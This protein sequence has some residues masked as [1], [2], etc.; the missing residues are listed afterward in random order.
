MISSRETTRESSG[1]ESA[2][3]ATNAFDRLVAMYAENNGYAPALADSLL[4]K[5]AEEGGLSPEDFARKVFVECGFNPDGTE[6]PVEA[7]IAESAPATNPPV[8]AG[9]RTR[10]VSVRGPDGK[11]IRKRVRIPEEQAVPAVDAP[12]AGGEAAIAESA[13]AAKPPVVDSIQ[14][15]ADSYP[16]LP[17]AAGA[18]VINILAAPNGLTWQGLEVEEEDLFERIGIF[19]QSEPSAFLRIQAFPDTPAAIVRRIVDA[20]RKAGFS[21]VSVLLPAPLRPVP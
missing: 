13:P 6:K 17:V 4:R 3:A 1:A 16:A 19:G 7:G 21:R 18:P 14:S 8:P 15:L 10:C 5:E 20:A 12:A 11:I 9:P 2:P